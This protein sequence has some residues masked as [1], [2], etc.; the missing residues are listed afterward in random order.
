MSLQRGNTV[1][2]TYT[3]SKDPLNFS[4]SYQDPFV[5][6]TRESLVPG[7]KKAS[8]SKYHS[9]SSLQP[10]QSRTTVNPI[11]GFALA[12]LI[13]QAAKVRIEYQFASRF[14]G[15]D[16]HGGRQSRICCALTSD[17]DT[18]R[19][20]GAKYGIRGNGL[21][22]VPDMAGNDVATPTSGPDVYSVKASRSGGL[23]D[24]ACRSRINLPF[25]GG[26]NLRL[27]TET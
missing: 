3:F 6:E 11:P 5:S 14:A 9:Q 12:V 10:Y 13:S 16:R 26:S 25:P 7:I 21:A 1:H 17:A 27:F 22:V 2:C 15:C 23:D 8:N 24:W 18:Q 4:H 19:R 20:S